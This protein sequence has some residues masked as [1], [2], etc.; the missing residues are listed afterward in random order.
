MLYTSVFAEFKIEAAVLSLKKPPILCRFGSG[1]GLKVQ[2]G[3][4]MNIKSCE[5]GSLHDILSSG[6][7]VMTLL[8]HKTVWIRL[9]TLRVNKIQLSV[10][11][12][13]L[14][15]TLSVYQEFLY[16]SRTQTATKE[17]F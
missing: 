6:N 16:L 17:D 4:V 5:T 12:L 10:L 14:F 2:L 1:F 11:N 13:F 7:D 8:N 9:K 3:M 15:T